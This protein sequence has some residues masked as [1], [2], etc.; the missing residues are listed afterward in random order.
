MFDT[1]SRFGKVGRKVRSRI[2][3]HSQR[4]KSATRSVFC[5]NGQALSG[6]PLWQ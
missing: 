1:N 4:A 5:C 6:M 2:E 3:S